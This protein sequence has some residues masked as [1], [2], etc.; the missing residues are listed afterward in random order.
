MT[1][2]DDLPRSGQIAF[3]AVVTVMIITPAVVLCG[4]IF[5]F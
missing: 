5:H 3:L 4:L 2:F 1:P